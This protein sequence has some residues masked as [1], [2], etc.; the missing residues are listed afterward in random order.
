MTDTRQASGAARL[1]WLAAGAI[2]FLLVPWYSLHDSVFALSWILHF[3]SKEAAPALLQVL[4]HGKAW[5]VPVGV[6]LAIA[7]VPVF[8][9][10]ERKTRAAWLTAIG[11]TGFVYAL[12]QGFAI[13]PAGW[14]F[15]SLASVLP[16]CRA[17]SSEWDWA[18]RSC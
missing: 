11:A 18:P 5:L 6:L 10:R 14:S 2:G 12:L 1:F 7:V 17:A 8:V 4:L 15:E 9:T 3:T 16:R 13:G